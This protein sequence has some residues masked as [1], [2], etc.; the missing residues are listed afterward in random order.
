[1]AANIFLK[2]LSELTHL[3]WL[4]ARQAGIGGSDIAK[5]LG[6]TPQWG[7]QLEVY[8][9]K[10]EE[11]F[12]ETQTDAQFYGHAMEPILLKRF[13]EKYDLKIFK[14]NC[15]YQS[16]KTPFA[17][18]NLDGFIES[19]VPMIW[20]CK[21]AGATKTKEWERGVPLYYEMQ[22]QWYMYIMEV[23]A[24]WVSVLIGGNDERHYQIDRDPEKIEKALVAAS[25]VWNAVEK[26]SPPMAKKGDHETVKK[27]YSESNAGET[28]ELDPEMERLALNHKAY[29]SA[30][31]QLAEQVDMIETRLKD[32]LKEKEIAVGKE[33]TVSWKKTKDRQ[34]F[35][36]RAFKK[37]KPFEYKA[38]EVTKTG[39]RVF[40]VSGGER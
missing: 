26:K 2:D 13:E 17:L 40:K 16:S 25:H 39:H 15:I 31:K 37:E 4:K 30:I 36:A 23:Q 24:A 22:V 19:P 21:T 3:Q 12:E 6:L 29:K 18:A 10:V 27:F 33:Y 14:P 1:M 11:P 34:S 38:W 32:Y 20:E 5:I 28:I 35:D 8:R 7:N 9:Q